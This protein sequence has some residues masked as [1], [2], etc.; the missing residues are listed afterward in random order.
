MHRCSALYKYY[1]SSAKYYDSYFTQPVAIYKDLHSKAGLW[2]R[3][4]F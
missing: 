1:D 2:S 3:K 4:I